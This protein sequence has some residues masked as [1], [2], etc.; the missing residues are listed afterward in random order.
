[1]G[2]FNIESEEK[3]RKNFQ[4][5]FYLKQKTFSQNPDRLIYIDLILTNSNLPSL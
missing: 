4:N 2:D 5:T 1:M 3:P